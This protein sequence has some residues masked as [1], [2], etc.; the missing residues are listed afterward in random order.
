M[1]KDEG[2]KK[3]LKFKN[4]MRMS[5]DQIRQRIVD[6]DD[7]YT[8]ADIDQ[9]F[10]AQEIKDAGPHIVPKPKAAKPAISLADQ[11]KAN[12]NKLVAAGALEVK[13]NEI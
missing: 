10:S 3:Y 1:E 8:Q 6:A 12:Q 11:L 7:S 2:F 5:L 4:M 13:Q 9:F